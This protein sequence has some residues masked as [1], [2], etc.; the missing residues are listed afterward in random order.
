MIPDLRLQKGKNLS[1]YVY[2]SL[3]HTFLVMVG[4]NR[5]Q[6]SIFSYSHTHK[7]WRETV[8]SS[9]LHAYNHSLTKMEGALPR[10]GWRQEEV[11][12]WLIF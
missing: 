5:N 11:K 1:V 3:D 2:L 4:Q 7:E 10:T 9:T 8:L 12:A 6:S